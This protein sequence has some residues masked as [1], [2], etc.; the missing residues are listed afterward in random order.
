[1]TNTQQLRETDCYGVLI[2]GGLRPSSRDWSW[3]RAH[4]SRLA[5]AKTERSFDRTR[6]CSACRYA[7]IHVELCSRRVTS[8]Q[9]E[10]RTACLASGSYR[11][12]L[13]LA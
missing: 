13:Q 4:E 1:M 5:G 8:P 11:R 7:Q 6:F 12:D 2:S 9:V 10:K 3:L